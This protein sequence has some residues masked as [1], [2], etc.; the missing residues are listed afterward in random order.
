[1]GGGVGLSYPTSMSDRM[2]T[3]VSFPLQVS[4]YHLLATEDSSSG[5]GSSVRLT[6]AEL[7]GGRQWST[8]KVFS[9]QGLNYSTSSEVTIGGNGEAMVSDTLTYRTFCTSS[10]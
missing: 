9:G 2:I 10:T 3:S 4:W 8:S 6:V 1:M 7:G 5:T